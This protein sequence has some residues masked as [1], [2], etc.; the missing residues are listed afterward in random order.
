MRPFKHLFRFDLEIGWCG[1]M[2]K[3]TTKFSRK[4]WVIKKYNFL[5]LA[6]LFNVPE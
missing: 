2:N 1:F 5:G 6:I 3:D 4:Y